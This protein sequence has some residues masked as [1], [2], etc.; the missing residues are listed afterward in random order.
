MMLKINLL[1]IIAIVSCLLPIGAESFAEEIK[2]P[3]GKI[4]FY[5]NLRLYFYDV[6]DSRCPSD[7]TCIWEGKILAM[8]QVSN[9]TH[10]IGGPQNIGFVQKSFEPYSIRLKNVEPYPIS[11]EKL[12]YVAI[13]EIT[14]PQS[15]SDEFTDEQVC[16]V[17][18][19][20][21]DGI[22]VP[23]DNFRI[24]DPDFSRQNLQTGETISHPEVIMIIE[25]LGAILI[26]SFIV[27]YTIKKRRKRK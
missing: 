19:I 23:S 24:D 8:I 21:V 27:I 18:F 17:G 20:I 1:I 10:E 5:E 11:T 15:R 25:S 22:C 2:I 13:L 7:I 12:V 16:G 9:S 14:N 6:E 26:V 4:V 3:F